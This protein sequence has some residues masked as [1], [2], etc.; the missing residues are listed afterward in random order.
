MRTS[1]LNPFDIRACVQTLREWEARDR[2]NV[3]IPLISG[4]VFKREEFEKWAHE[5]GS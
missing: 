3:L 5:N 2:F 1:C 4:H